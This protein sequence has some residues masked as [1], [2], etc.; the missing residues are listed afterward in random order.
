M[1]AP[2]QCLVSM[3]SGKV[4]HQ[5]QAH[6]KPHN[7]DMWTSHRLSARRQ[8]GLFP[9]HNCWCA[10]ARGYPRGIYIARGESKKAGGNKPCGLLSK[11]WRHWLWLRRT[12]C[13]QPIPRC[14]FW[15]RP[16]P[17]DQEISSQ[18]RG[19]SLGWLYLLLLV[20]RRSQWPSQEEQ[21]RISSTDPHRHII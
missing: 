18:R 7:K 12:T 17:A 21:I 1:E 11:R 9:C 2:S 19:P 8:Q 14:D 3:L 10:G 16:G 15:K 6:C 4:L 5:G 13:T 20:W